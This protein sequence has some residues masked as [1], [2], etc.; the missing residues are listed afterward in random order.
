MCVD[1]LGF[2]LKSRTNRTRTGVWPTKRVTGRLYTYL[3]GQDR[4]NRHYSRSDGKIGVEDNE[5]TC[6]RH[7]VEEFDESMTKNL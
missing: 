2:Y 5:V 1:S 6:M 7:K 4:K 3:R